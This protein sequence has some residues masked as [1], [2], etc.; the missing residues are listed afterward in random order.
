MRILLVVV[1]AGMAVIFVVSFV[2]PRASRKVQE[3]VKLYTGRLSERARRRASKT[4]DATAQTFEKAGRAT[5]S[6]GH[7]GRRA[8]DTVFRSSAGAAQERYLRRRHGEGAER[9]E[10]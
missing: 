7:A 1:L 8:H 4:G 2:R 10:E 9:G 3:T 6:V 5:Q